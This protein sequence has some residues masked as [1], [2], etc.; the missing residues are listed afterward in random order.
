MPVVDGFAQPAGGGG[1]GLAA[2]SG[3]AKAP[4]VEKAMEGG[5]GVGCGVVAR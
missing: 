2:A 5:E 1:S 3:A 4:L